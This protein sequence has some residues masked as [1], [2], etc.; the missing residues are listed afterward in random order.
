MKS[1][2]L[3]RFKSPVAA[4][5]SSGLRCIDETVTTADRL[6]APYAVR[7]HTF[8]LILHRLLPDEPALPECCANSDVSA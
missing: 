7:F 3:L 4:W 1:L 5:D 2:K 6:G 8:L